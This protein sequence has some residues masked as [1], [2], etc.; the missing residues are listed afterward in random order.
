M[1]NYYDV[2]VIGGGIIGCS[3][4][5]QL[6]KQGVKVAIVE[7]NQIG[8]EASSA[9]A[10]ILGAQA[11]IDEEGPLLSLAIKSRAMFP[12]LVE[13]LK[14]KTGIDVELIQKG[15]LKVAMS[16]EEASKLQ[17]RV[18]E[19]HQWNENVKWITNKDVQ[20]LEN[21][22]SSATY[23]AIH[24]PDDGQLAP[25]KLTKAF[26]LA[27]VQE[28]AQ[29][30][31]FCQVE[32]LHIED[33]CIKGIQTSVGMLF[34]N[35]VICTTGS[36]ANELLT[37]Y[38]PSLHVF[39][40]K[41]ECISVRS[42]I[43]LLEKT[44]FLD[45]GFYLV[46]KSEG[47]IIIGA[48][49]IPR[50][51]EKEVSLQGVSKLVEKAQRLLPA[52]KEATF[53]KAWAGLRPQTIDGWPYLGPHPKVQGLFVAFGHYRNGILLSAITGQLLADAVLKKSMNHSFF[54]DFRLDRHAQQKEEVHWS[55]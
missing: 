7:R 6:A 39:P 3:T 41:G 17:K 8:C 52:I 2:L 11:E 50:T 53:E 4:A 31:G 23:G 45:E 25:D 55:Y 34:A 38:K 12:T 19:H 35:H 47:R 24:I 51:F 46:P 22:L 13:E 42:S 43:Q 10:G 15:L 5:Y 16:E 36:W 29:V 27:A 49:K 18:K 20:E 33:G 28:G 32:A 14:E 1:N 37:P 9:A 26:A 21:G 30:H 54:Q 44:I 40:V 48:T